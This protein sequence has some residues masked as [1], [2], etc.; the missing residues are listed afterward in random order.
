MKLEW[1]KRGLTISFFG[2]EIRSVSFNIVNVESTF[3]GVS[4]VV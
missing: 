1:Q 2:N 3:K 4:W